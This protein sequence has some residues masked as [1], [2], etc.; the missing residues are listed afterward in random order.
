MS[1]GEHRAR[2]LE[3]ELRDLTS[4]ISHDLRAPLRA[5]EGFSRALLETAPAGLD[6]ESVHYLSRIRQ[7]S[8]QLARRIEGLMRLGRASAYTLQLRQINLAALARTV[9][10]ALR[11]SEPDRQVTVDIPDEL[12]AWA[13]PTLGGAL[14]EC[15]LANAWKFSR[16]SPSARIELGRREQDGEQVYFVRDSGMGFDMAGADKLFQPFVRLHAAADDDGPGIGL[17]L[18]RRIVARHHG[19]IWA[20]AAPGRG[21]IFYFTLAPRTPV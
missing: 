16:S 17:A 5:V 4:A 2:Q 3:Q 14:L 19:R 8:Q 9:V 18:A 15:L 7:A 10:E 13:D 21:A 1:E 20:D 11:Q 6:A 12:V